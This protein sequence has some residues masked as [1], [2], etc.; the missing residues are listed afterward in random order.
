VEAT[1]LGWIDT[2]EAGIKDPAPFFEEAGVGLGDG[3]DFGAPGF[4]RLGFACPRATLIE[5]LDRMSRAME[6]PT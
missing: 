5:A 3:A 2:R 4:V 1:Y 6:K